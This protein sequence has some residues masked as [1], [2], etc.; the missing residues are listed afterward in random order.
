MHS[1]ITKQYSKDV[2]YCVLSLLAYFLFKEI[3]KVH[4]T[5][6]LGVC[7]RRWKHPQWERPCPTSATKEHSRLSL[8]GDWL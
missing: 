1:T 3:N 6:K 4:E 8:Y 5:I 2:Y 7:N